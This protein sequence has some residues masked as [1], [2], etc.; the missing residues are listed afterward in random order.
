MAILGQKSSKWPKSLFSGAL[1]SPFGL[2]IGDI[3][4]ISNV[5][6]LSGVEQHSIAL[7]DNGLVFGNHHFGFFD[8]I[9]GLQDHIKG[10][11]V[12]FNH[13]FK[14][15]HVFGHGGLD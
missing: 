9:F 2:G 7:F 8:V 6:V 3:A 5:A 11:M 13:L 1:T 4:L 15:R 12:M 10:F 14:D